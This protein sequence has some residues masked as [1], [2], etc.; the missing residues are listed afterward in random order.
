[1]KK[2]GRPRTGEYRNCEVCDKEFYVKPSYVKLGGGKYCS[3]VCQGKA[4]QTRESRKCLICEKE[5]Y[6][7]PSHLK[8][9][10]GKYC[11]KI[12]QGKTIKGPGNPMWN[13]GIKRDGQGY[14]RML[15][16]DH[17]AA[18]SMGYVFQHRIIM[19]QSLDRYLKL[20]EVVHHEN[21][22]ASDNRPENLRLFENNA[23]HMKHHAEKR[24]AG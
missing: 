13:G 6:V 17:P 3:R 14:L 8:Y 23:E 19:E 22:D 2:L 21:E 11:S 18:D 16:P 1:M 5:F 7:K 4:R 9:G 12:C 20:G 15:A 10:R 24:T